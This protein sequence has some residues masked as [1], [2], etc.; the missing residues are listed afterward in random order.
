MDN[1]R[2]A[3]VQLVLRS[4]GLP[5]DLAQAKFILWLRS[6]GLEAPV[7]EALKEEQLRICSRKC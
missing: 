2:L 6:S 3:F 1:V 4:A 5:E 7:D